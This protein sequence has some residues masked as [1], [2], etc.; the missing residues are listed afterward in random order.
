MLPRLIHCVALLVVLSIAG[1][2][3]K[4]SNTDSSAQSLS[5]DTIELHPADP[6][7]IF[8][9]WDNGTYLLEVDADFAW[10]MRKGRS[11]SAR[12][13]ERGRWTR[14]N[15]AV[16]Y[17]EPY[18]R[19]AENERVALS[20]VEGQ[21]RATIKDMPPFRHLAGAPQ[22][23]RESLAGTWTGGKRTL[24]IT[25]DM[26]YSLV[27]TDAEQQIDGIWLI[28]DGALVLEPKDPEVPALVLTLERGPR[29]GV[30]ALRGLDSP[31]L[32]ATNASN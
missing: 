11:A 20:L 6:I 16:F 7:S 12:V 5:R 30:I 18:I 19:G 9:W 32:Q 28:Q 27:H 13:I 8:G 24:H 21:P 29:G 25:P 10:R 4:W 26:T 1:C 31:L 23:I 14:E 2:S 22:S 17:L 3:K 15:H